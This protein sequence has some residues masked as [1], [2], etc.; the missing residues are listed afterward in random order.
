MVAQSEPNLTTAHFVYKTCAIGWASRTSRKLDYCVQYKHTHTSQHTMERTRT[1]VAERTT[2]ISTNSHIHYDSSVR[3][4]SSKFFFPLWRANVYMSF[5]AS[6]IDLVSLNTRHWNVT[7][8]WEWTE[9][10]KMCSKRCM[11][12]LNITLY[13][14]NW[15]S[16]D[17]VQWNCIAIC[18]VI[19]YA[20]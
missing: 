5:V 19:I 11:L 6:P 18:L 10:N 7:Q 17:D 16:G 9:K 8:W 14:I 3:Q 12:N 4:N 20:T 13:R 15:T 2:S 1:I